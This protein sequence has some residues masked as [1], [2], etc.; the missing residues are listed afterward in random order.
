M[1]QSTIIL[2]AP[3][4]ND[5]GGNSGSIYL[6]RRKAGAWAQSEKIVGSDIDADDRFGGAIALRGGTIF[7]GAANANDAGSVYVYE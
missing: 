7:V 4:D 1:T 6:F 3:L 2:G 5:A